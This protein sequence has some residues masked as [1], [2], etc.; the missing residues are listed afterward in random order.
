MLAE[1]DGR[2]DALGP[3]RLRS[4]ALVESERLSADAKFESRVL[5]RIPASL[6]K[7]FCTKLVGVSFK[8]DDN[9]S[10][11]SNIKLLSEGQ[12]LVLQMQ[13][14]NE[15]DENAILVCTSGG[16][17]LGHL[18]SRLAG[19]VTRSLKRGKGWTCFVRRLLSSPGSKKVGVTLFMVRTATSTRTA[20]PVS[21]EYP[22][23][24]PRFLAKHYPDYKR[25]R[26]RECE[27]RNRSGG[28]VPLLHIVL[29]EA[30]VLIIRS[31]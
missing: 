4:S 8:N 21:A 26:A 12:E 17:G 22:M 11:Q 2:E 24:G 14:D 1:H 7:H 27:A 28:L 20:N 23:S 5:E 13:P 31:S 3:L 6:E 25:E 10:R 15:Y 18:D 19:E 9:T 29:M 30:V 16:A